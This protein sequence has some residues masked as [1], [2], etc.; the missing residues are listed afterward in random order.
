[1]LR[2]R[3]IRVRCCIVRMLE[4][5]LR[6]R[7]VTRK[8]YYDIAWQDSEN[9]LLLLGHLIKISVFKRAC[10]SRAVFFLNF[11]ALFE[12]M[13]SAICVNNNNNRSELIDWVVTIVAWERHESFSS[14][15]SFSNFSRDNNA[16]PAR[17]MHKSKKAKEKNKDYEAIDS[18]STL[19]VNK[20]YFAT[21]GIS[22]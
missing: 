7:H 14:H 19:I 22:S 10:A 1:M 2:T 21:P 11:S 20:F 13:Q 8:S 16:A 12:K 5:I 6:A 15:F 17:L 4:G 18:I 9:T 3:G